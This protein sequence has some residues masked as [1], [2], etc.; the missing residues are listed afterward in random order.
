M[1]DRLT[2]ETGG[3]PRWLPALAA[4]LLSVVLAVVGRFVPVVTTADGSSAAPGV[5]P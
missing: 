5:A 1:T 3:R 4:L 2:S